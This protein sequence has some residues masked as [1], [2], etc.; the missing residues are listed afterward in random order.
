MP[1]NPILL[2][3]LFTTIGFI[4]GAVVAYFAFRHEGKKA[5]TPSE[6][7][8]LTEREK[9]FQELA[10][11]WR[12]RVGGKL[13]IWFGGKMVDNPQHLDAIQRQKL[14]SVGR[15]LMAWL[16]VSETSTAQ[17]AE[18]QEAGGPQERTIATPPE[19]QAVEPGWRPD[20]APLLPIVPAIKDT[21]P[22]KPLSIVEQVD[23]IL[24][25]IVAGTP[26]ATRMIRLVEDPKSGVV[27][28]VG[29]EH[30]NGVDTVPDPDIKAI[31]R[32]AGAEWE[33][34]SERLRR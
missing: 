33:R 13:T 24:Q 19:V 17:A 22:A 30:Y 28:W 15:E 27:V 9:R 32:K 25:E 2:I 4:V 21:K 23:E 6:L 5:P 16:G 29:L 10:G 1:T 7:D 3:F 8:L 12:E 31:L 14:E 18:K 26:L 11:L 34:R 20:T